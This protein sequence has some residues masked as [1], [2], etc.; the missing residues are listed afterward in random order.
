MRPTSASVLFICNSKLSTKQRRNCN[1]SQSCLTLE[2]FNMQ[3]FSVVSYL[4]IF[5]YA[6]FLSHVLSQ[7]ISICNVSQS[8][9]ILANV[10]MQC[11]LVMSYLSK[12]QYFEQYD[13]Q[14]AIFSIFRSS[15]CM[16]YCYYFFHTPFIKGLLSLV[17]E[18]LSNSE[19]PIRSPSLASAE[20]PV[21]NTSSQDLNSCG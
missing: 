5:Q 20:K 19:K 3:C 6:M 14:I 4:S 16:L 9:L 21:S 13:C 2:N 1:I 10:N 17:I 18:I 7:Q 8:C 15:Y 12:F 11:F